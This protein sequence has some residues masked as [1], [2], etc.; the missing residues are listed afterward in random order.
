MGRPWPASF[1]GVMKSANTGRVAK[2]GHIVN[3]KLANNGYI[4][5]A[6]KSLG[7]RI[8]EAAEEV[9]GLNNLA[10]K[11]DVPRRTLGNW[12]RGTRP[13]PEALSK[14]ANATSVSLDWLV[15][16]EGEKIGGSW[17]AAFSNAMARLDRDQPTLSDIEA[18]KAAAARL[19]AQAM[20]RLG[21]ATPSHEPNSALGQ[22]RAGVIDV[23]L[24]QELHDT[25]QAVY[26]ECKRT[27]PPRA[28]TADAGD[29]YNELSGMVSDI[30]DRAVVAALL[31]IVRERFKERIERAE[32]GSS[33]AEAS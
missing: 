17:S 10:L 8:K 11:I 20:E 22:H 14:I 19:F 21:A 27:P 5:N 13:R 16:G 3:G 4:G 2:N 9:G 1:F 24:L 7:D 12:L 31:P 23:V 33:K 32:P 30:T 18:E 15:S 26:A 29:L 25:V 28:V 6:L